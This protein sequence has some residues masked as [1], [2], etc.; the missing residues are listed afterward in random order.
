MNV[1]E[2]AE[3]AGSSLTGMELLLR[4]GIN[5]V[6][7]FILIGL[8]YY[9]LHRQKDYLFTFMLINVLIFFICALLSTSKLKLGFAFGLFAVFSM[10]RYRTVTVPVKEMG[11]FFVSVAMAVINALASPEDYY[12]LLIGPDVLMLLLVLILDRYVTIS[13]ENVKEV[14]Y[15]RIELIKPERRA[16][17]LQDLTARTG[18]PVHRVEIVHINFLRD[19]A[20]INMYYYAPEIEKSAP[21]V[22]TPDNR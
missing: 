21:I 22:T 7:A 19:V 3:L 18:L 9:P 20:T 10:M 5:F 17:L 4:F 14:I 13:H 16:E 8:I 2:L 15:E 6:S 11:Y 12:L 1:N